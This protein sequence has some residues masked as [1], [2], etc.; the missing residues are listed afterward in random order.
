M[1]IST[2][3]RRDL[4]TA[5][6]GKSLSSIP[7]PMGRRRFMNVKY[8]TRSPPVQDNYQRQLP[9]NI[10]ITRSTTVKFSP[11]VELPSGLVS[12][13]ALRVT[14][15]KTRSQGGRGLVFALTSPSL[16]S[17]T[18]KSPLD[19][20][21]TGRQGA[22]RGR[23]RCCCGAARARPAPPLGRT[24]CSPAS[25]PAHGKCS[26]RVCRIDVD[27]WALDAG[28]CSCLC[29]DILSNDPLVHSHSPR[30]QQ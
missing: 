21:L 4:E 8:M 18:S 15:V 20:P 11:V 19:R 7:E 26:V 13:G 1:P 17:S 24:P 30:P 29:G 6:S 5:A 22:R 23:P 2:C 28:R 10:Q 12:G 9:I 27:G 14:A 16:A 25:P 3:S